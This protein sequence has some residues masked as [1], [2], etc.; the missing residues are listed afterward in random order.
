MP[1][2]TVLSVSTYLEIEE[3]NQ[4][5]TC[6]EAAAAAAVVIARAPGRFLK[7]RPLVR[8]SHCICEPRHTRHARPK[9]TPDGH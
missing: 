6:A 1:Y 3:Y 5:V 7:S 2:P 9:C 8:S 4:A